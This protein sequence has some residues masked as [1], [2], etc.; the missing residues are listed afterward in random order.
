MTSVRSLVGTYG[1]L[2]VDIDQ[3]SDSDDLYRAGLTSHACVALMLACEEEY[4][5]EF[6]DDL[7]RRSTFATLS[8]LESALKTLGADLDADVA[9]PR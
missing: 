7:V 9:Q 6:T 8:A 4:D 2:S 3:V 1:R 5:V